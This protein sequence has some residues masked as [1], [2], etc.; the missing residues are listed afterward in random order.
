[1]IYSHVR[2]DL[3]R[4]L[5]VLG[6]LDLLN[7]FATSPFLALGLSKNRQLVFYYCSNTS[8][9]LELVLCLYICRDDWSK[10]GHSKTSG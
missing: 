7:S 4:P 9:Q 2:E 5:G 3:L 6:L 8:Q 10:T 1:M